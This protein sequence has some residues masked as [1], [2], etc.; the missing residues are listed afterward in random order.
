VT[1]I[2]TSTLAVTSTDLPDVA[3]LADSARPALSVWMPT[4]RELPDSAARLEARW[5][6]ARQQLSDAGAPDE[7]LDDAERLLDELR[8]E[9]STAAVVTDGTTSIAMAVDHDLPELTRWDAL[10]ALAPWVEWH[11]GSPPGVLA[12]V[13]R[14]G[15]DLFAT[16]SDLPVAVVEGETGPV[17]RRS[18]PGGWSQRRFQQRAEESW[19]ANGALVAEEL[20]AAAGEVGARV[21][22][23]AGDVRALKEVRDQLPA[24]LADLVRLAAGGRGEGSTGHMEDDTRRWYR[25]AVA[26]DAVTLIR[27]FEEQLGAG[28]RAAAGLDSVTER[29]RAA[30][31]DTLLVHPAQLEGRRLL[32]QRNAPSMVGTDAA[33]L[34]GDDLVDADATDALIAAAWAS[35]AGVR[36]VPRLSSL[37]DGVGAMLRF[38]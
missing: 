23:M 19:R 12:V 29:L 18:A 2:A 30:A 32:T 22:V 20:A 34:P 14:T 7:V 37:Q 24:E 36:V 21:I 1:S 8:P 26:E 5:R 4:E 25:T 28:H 35:G 38:P 16:G 10:P 15:A 9:A 13:D 3:E 33:Q 31:V 17:I 6:A 11:Q 27:Q